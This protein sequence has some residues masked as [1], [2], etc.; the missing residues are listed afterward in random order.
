MGPCANLKDYIT[1][2][3]TAKTDAFIIKLCKQD[4]EFIYITQLCNMGPK[5]L[6]N[7]ATNNK[8]QFW[9]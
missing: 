3:N 4:Q 1:A 9:R 8:Q 5:G 2:A 6:K 7:E